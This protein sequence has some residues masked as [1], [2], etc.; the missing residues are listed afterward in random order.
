MNYSPYRYDKSTLSDEDIVFRKLGQ[1]YCTPDQLVSE[2]VLT[3][4][5]L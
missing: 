2:Q 3:Y 4:K 1:A 5:D